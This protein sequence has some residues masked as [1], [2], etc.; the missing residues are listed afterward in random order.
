MNITS[1]LVREI[2]RIWRQAVWLFTVALPY[3]FIWWLKK[4]TGSTDGTVLYVGLPMHYAMFARIHRLLPDVRLVAADDQAASALRKLGVAHTQNLLYPDTVIMAD[5][6]HKSYPVAAIKKVQIF[7]GTGCKNW[8]CGRNNRNYLC[9]VPGSQLGE[10]LAELGARAIEI[11]GYP[12]TDGF[13]DGSLDA[14]AIGRRLGLDPGKRTILYAPTWGEASSAPFLTDAVDALAADYNIIVKLHDLSPTQWREKYRSLSAVLFN[15]DADITECLFVADLL[16]SD[17]SSTIFEFAQL[18]RPIISFGMSDELLATKAIDPAW[19]AI[20]RR[21][22][23]KAELA[24]AVAQMLTDWSADKNYKELVKSIFAH[25]DG[26]AAER[27]ADA[28]RAWAEESGVK[29]WM[30]LSL[31]RV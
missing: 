20:T 19:W 25:D 15:E 1:K 2:T 27:A 14:P 7:H 28:I 9:L 5:Y 17:F 22:S 4:L 3:N 13:F 8:F 30:R 23:D 12:K 29:V 18:H 31:P 11:V 10:R 6:Y 26:R 21:V 16:I 24:P